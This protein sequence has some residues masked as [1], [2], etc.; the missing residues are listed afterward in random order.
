M[1]S[2]QPE[3]A[4]GVN[5]PICDS[6]TFFYR[7]PATMKG[8]F[9]G[10]VEDCYLY[11]RH[12][13]PSSDALAAGVA[14][15]EGSESAVVTA[16]GMAAI[17]CAVLQLAQAGDEIVASRMLYGGTYALFKN[18][19][20]RFGITVKFVDMRDLGSVQ[21]AISDKTRVVFTESVSNPL[22]EVCDI[23]A[24]ADMTHGV[25]AQLLV[26]NTFCPLVMRPLAL[27]ADIVIHSM[28][29]YINGSSDCVAG[30]ICCSAEFRARLIDV[31][32][33]MSML[34]GP[35]LD[36]IRA[37]S[38][39]KN[40]GTLD[41]RMERHSRNAAMVSNA[42]MADGAKVYYPGHESHPQ[43]AL[44]QRQKRPC[45]GDSGMVVV[46]AGSQ[47]RARQFMMG[48]ESRGVGLIAVSLGFHRTLI[49][50]PGG[51]TSSEIP[52]EERHAMGLTDGLVRLSVG[53][54]S[55]IERTIRLIS[56]AWIASA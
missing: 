25:G 50:N 40:L 35:T 38:I 19:F 32:D 37:A 3:H 10:E 48:M 22:L 51:S 18:V 36:A 34:L 2:D 30:A 16:S 12:S 47:E 45:Q 6:S 7:D 49:S 21:A 54:D 9:A 14:A 5:P 39:L 23:A 4:F 20:P 46:D 13:H 24:L 42:L 31:G 33:G 55:D 15:M 52:E 44:F 17:T 28:T 56:E 8:V 53:L 27:G 41:V 26:D 43:Y 29:K 11:S 1:T